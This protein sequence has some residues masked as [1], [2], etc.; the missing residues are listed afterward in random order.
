[1]DIP[2]R[3]GQSR[4]LLGLFGFEQESH[5]N[6]AVVIGRSKRSGRSVSDTPKFGSED[7][8]QEIEDRGRCSFSVEWEPGTGTTG[9]CSM[10]N[11]FPKKKVARGRV[12]KA[13]DIRRPGLERLKMEMPKAEKGGGKGEWEEKRVFQF[14]WRRCSSQTSLSSTAYMYSGARLRS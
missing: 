13:S 10:R 4:A 2:S 12:L 8:L 11:S 9:S 6:Y 5:R 1:M 3:R 14:P 7:V